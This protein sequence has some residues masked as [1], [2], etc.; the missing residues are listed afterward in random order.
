M[1]TLVEAKGFRSLKYVSRPLDNFMVLVG[2]N[3]SGKTSFLDTIGFI[4]DLLR[5]GPDAAVRLRTDT[6]DVRHLSWNRKDDSFELAIQMTIPPYIRAKLPNGGHNQCR[7]EVAVGYDESSGIV[8]VLGEQFWLIRTDTRPRAPQQRSVFPASF[9]PPRTILT[10]GKTPPGWRKIVNKVRDSG[11]DYFRSETGKWNNLFR[12]GPHKAALANLP[13]DQDK[14]PVASWAKRWLM[15]GVQTLI[16]NSRAMRRPS[17]PRSPRTYQPDGSNLALVV[18]ELHRRNKAAFDQWIDHVR[19]ALPELDSIRIAQRPEDRHL[20]LVA[21]YASG[22]EVPS[23]LISDGT[24]RLIALTLLAYLPVQG[25]YLIEEPENG[26]HPKAVE[27]VFQ[28]LSSVYE[29]QVL[30]A[31]HSPVILNLADPSQVLCFART[32]EGATDIVLGIEHPRLRDWQGEV[33]LGT[34]LASGVLG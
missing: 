20:Y 16:L 28:S 2:P 18:S 10:T 9:D 13:E 27:T 5:D 19:T 14:F 12:L 30:I 26:I 34:L 22:L 4:S 11:N 32:S 33:E 25:T 17:S 3:A 1:I 7:Y 31:T 29:A 8:R 21:Q 6:G 15:E 24:L 23:W